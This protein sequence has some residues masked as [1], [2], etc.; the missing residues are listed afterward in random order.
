MDKEN[1]VKKEIMNVTYDTIDSVLSSLSFGVPVIG[2]IKS[3]CSIV[4]NIQNKRLLKKIFLF[5]NE[6]SIDEKELDTFLN[7]E[8]IGSENEQKNGELLF[9]YIDSIDD[10]RKATLIGKTLGYIL[11]SNIL[12]QKRIFFKF[13]HLV[14]NA[15]YDDLESILLFTTKE[16]SITSG[17]DDRL[18]DLFKSG[19][20]IDMG[21]DGGSWDAQTPEE[22]GGTIFKLNKFG[23][24]L[25]DVFRL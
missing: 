13:S 18:E 12:N 19:F 2:T 22:E 15:Y 23:E 24:I 6:I 16:N 10:L 4:G 14:I 21:I 11:K 3:I 8:V 9:V 1:N 20:L 17:I 25:Y 7:S 5:L